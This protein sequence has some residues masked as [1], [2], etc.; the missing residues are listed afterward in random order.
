MRKRR[1]AALSGLAF[2]VL[3]VGLFAYQTLSSNDT[4][5]A[6]THFIAFGVGVVAYA[7]FFLREA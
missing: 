4:G 5:S 3:G 2:I 6:P 1:R 7:Y